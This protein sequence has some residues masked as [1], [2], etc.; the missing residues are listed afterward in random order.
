MKYFLE[1]F[2]VLLGKEPKVY[3]REEWSPE[4]KAIYDDKWVIHKQDFRNYLGVYSDVWF[5]DVTI[6]ELDGK[7]H[8]QS[9]NSPKLKGDMIFYKGTTFII[10]WYDRSLDADAFAN[11]S[12]DN[13]A[14]PN[15]F[16]MEAIS[17]L[18]DFSFDFQD[19]DLKKKQ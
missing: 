5:G 1:N 13:N 11:F 8:F 18:T 4:A 12:L 10:K 9:K 15:G 16:K 14:A 17:P 6:S 7:M 3:P 2:L 19:L